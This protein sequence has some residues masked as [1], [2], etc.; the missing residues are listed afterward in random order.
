MKEK[1][2]CKLL[3]EAM[4]A[5]VATTTWFE[6]NNNEVSTYHSEGSTNENVT[7][8]IFYQNVA[9]KNTEQR[10]DHNVTL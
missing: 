8:H 10:I 5:F 1:T 7:K 9:V 3:H 2:D 4:R 6:R